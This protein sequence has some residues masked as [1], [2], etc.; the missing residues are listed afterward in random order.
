MYTLE[1]NLRAPGF[2]H[3]ATGY[4]KYLD[5][6]TFINFMWVNEAAKNIDGY[7]L[8]TFMY[9]DQDSKDSRLH[10]GP[11]WDYNLGFSNADYC[12]GPG[13]EGWA[14]DFND[15]CPGDFWVVHFWWQRLFNEPSFVK[16][17]KQEWVALESVMPLLNIR[18]CLS[19]LPGRYLHCSMQ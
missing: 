9:K 14:L 4:R 8:S 10:L 15:V 16:Q 1:E 19:P 18:H 5:P 13:Y 11:V 2:A 3:P 12:I 7:R 17:M 6:A